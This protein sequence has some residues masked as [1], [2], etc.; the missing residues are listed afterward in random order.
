M[1]FNGLALNVFFWNKSRLIEYYGWGTIRLEQPGIQL[2]RAEDRRFPRTQ[3]WGP[4]RG[5][6]S[7]V[8]AGGCRSTGLQDVL[9]GPLR[10]CALGCRCRRSRGQLT[11]ASGPASCFAGPGSRTLPSFDGACHG[12]CRD[13]REGCTEA[14]RRRSGCFDTA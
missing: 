1:F 2:Q 3:E 9:C 5:S 7:I 14:S 6:G 11:S 4:A 13:G 10:E 12:Q 8:Q